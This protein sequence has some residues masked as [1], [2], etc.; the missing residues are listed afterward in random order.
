MMLCRSCGAALTETFL[1]L[2]AM[3]VANAFVSRDGAEAMEPTYSLHVK[4][5]GDCRLVQLPAIQTP[6]AMF[7]DYIYFS[8]YAE[9]WL[10][11]AE[12]YATAMVARLGLGTGSAVVEVASNDGYLLQYFQ[13]RGVAVLGVEPAANVAAVAVAKGIATDIAFFGAATA[14]RLRRQGIVPDL[15]VANNVLAH[16]PDLDD[17][18]A[19]FAI[20]L[21]PHGVLT[22]EFPHLMTLVQGVQFDTIYHEHLSYFSLQVVR[23]IF[24][25]HGLHVFDVEPVPTHGGSLR[26]FVCPVPRPETAAVAAT[27]A[28]EQAAGLEQSATYRRLA[29]Q[30]AEAKCSLLGFLLRARSE[31]KRV[32]GYGAPAKGNTLLNYCGI[33][34]E[35]LAFT[36]DRSPHKQGMLLPGS[37][38]PV[39]S[40]EA[41]IEARPDYV[42]LLPWNL[43][44]EITASMAMVRDWGG[45][46]VV[47]IPATVVLE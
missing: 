42:L 22:V 37:R 3:P 2:G 46:F 45:R 43:A 27:V 29:A 6:E 15:V 39:L 21:P 17:F 18:V 47:P 35:L 38:I 8:S 19:G 9:S 10:R 30:V 5:C 40:P 44:A 32:V 26:V 24:A 11:H 34:P 33:G 13:Q 7:G 12:A 41:L 36:V 14:R 4:V 23:R 28:Q 20:L 25:R 1:D 16:V 31:G